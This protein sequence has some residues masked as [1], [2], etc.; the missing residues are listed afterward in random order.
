MT[1]EELD[2]AARSI[3][4]FSVDL[5]DQ[6]AP[7]SGNVVASPASVGLALAMVH[8][9]AKGKTADEIAGVLHVADS[10]VSSQRWSAAM[11]GLLARWNALSHEASD[12]EAELKLS[13][14]SRLFG[15]EATD[16][17]QSFVDGVGRDYGAPLEAVD[18]RSAAGD[19]RARIN[20][21]VEGRTFDRVDELVPPGGV[22][23]TTRLVLVNAVYLKGQWP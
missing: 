17:H 1:D 21:W 6:V 9:G 13:V 8:M 11:G 19:A 20:G 12:F 18:F 4:A 22:D 2:A 5:Y 14:V 7:D 16:F 15:D 10:Q 23:A 3:N